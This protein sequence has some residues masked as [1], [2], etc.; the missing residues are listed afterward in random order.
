MAP[1]VVVSVVNWNTPDATIACVRALLRQSY[2]NFEVVVVDNGS[3]DNSANRIRSALL[4]I[5]LLC[6]D[7]NAG[8]AAGHRIAVD[9][10]TAIGANGVWLVNSDAVA[11]PDA[12]AKLVN[13]WAALGDHVFGGLPVTGGY[14]SEIAIFPE[15][16]LDPQG[17]PGAFSRDRVRAVDAV[18][19]AGAPRRVSAVVG[20]SMLIPM[21]VIAGKGFMDDAWFMHCEE[22]DYCY[23]LRATGTLCYLVPQSRIHHKGGGSHSGRRKVSD[24]IAY[25][26]TRN[27]IQLTARHAS[28]V[29]AALVGTKKLLRA[30]T[31]LL[32]A[33]RRSML[34]ALGAL[35]G[36]IG[37]SG[38]QIDP[39]RAL[40]RDRRRG[41]LNGDFAARNVRRMRA[42]LQRMLGA[43]EAT[44]EK[45][46]AA[47][48]H[49]GQSLLAYRRD[50]V[51]FTR[52]YY[53][54][55]VALFSQQLQAL[56]VQINL[57]FGDYA[58]PADRGERFK[59]VD[60]QCEHTLVKPGGRDSDGALFGKV[61]LLDG[62]GCY[63]VR[64][65]N[66]QYFG[67]CD[68]IIEYSEPNIENLR[69]CGQFADH[70]SR[71]T[72]VSP[73]LYECNGERGHRGIDILTTFAD[74]RQPR[75]AAFLLNMRLRH[76]P[77]RN[78]RGSYGS[79]VLRDLLDATKILVNVHQTDHHHTLEEL[80]VLPAL[81]RG[82]IVI[83]ETVPLRECL[84]YD[85]F[86]VWSRYEDLAAT[87]ADVR[88]NYDAY[89]ER[90]FGGR[91]FYDVIAMMRVRNEYNV[92]TALKRL[93]ASNTD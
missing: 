92:S 74:S 79:L 9:H 13:V 2:P 83:S 77:M 8:F 33:P 39:D 48:E 6:N 88:A 64:L 30:A 60:L 36:L 50:H 67:D 57:L 12:L 29:T 43:G 31:L 38:K 37:R 14:G 90:I 55:C 1:K 66:A 86:V 73:L 21:N 42:V 4:R 18:V 3:T 32:I 89:R 24:A 82:V 10:A 80:R 17:R 65:A 20:S 63:R 23:R 41:V 71:T 11:E 16:F 46:V 85:R 54:Y 27:E 58:L 45:S 76:L 47:V 78:V 7:C 56:D 5:T 69:R 53:L 40:M 93:I 72:H 81:L 28:K 22:V 68:A 34:I 61:P 49:H 52:Q 59:R 70:L 91:A 26:R 87:V 62:E 15:K 51:I 44:G 84:P 19:Q 75:R 35:H 25:Y